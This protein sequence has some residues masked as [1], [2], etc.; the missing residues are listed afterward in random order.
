MSSASSEESCVCKG[1][2]YDEVF[3]PGQDDPGTS[4]DKRNLFAT[5]PSTKDE[6]LDTDGSESKSNDGQVGADPPTQSVIGPD[7]LREFIMLPLWTVN[8][9]ISSIK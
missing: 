4:S 7:G 8:D 6:D 5:L 1:A 3:P 2:G 9:F